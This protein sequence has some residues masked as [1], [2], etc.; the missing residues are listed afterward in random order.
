MVKP[1]INGR[2]VDSVVK[3][4]TGF[5]N[6]NESAATSTYVFVTQRRAISHGSSVHVQIPE[7]KPLAT[8]NQLLQVHYL[9][10]FPIFMYVQLYVTNK[11]L[12]F[13]WHSPLL[14]Y[15]ELLDDVNYKK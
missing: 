7:F 5:N 15:I 2:M 9:N 1:R 6:P 13:L 4:F 11:G 10:L 8:E 12:T 3:K 14:L